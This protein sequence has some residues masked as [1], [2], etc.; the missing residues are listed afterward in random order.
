MKVLIIALISALFVSTASAAE[1]GYIQGTVVDAATGLPIPYAAVVVVGT[2]LVGQTL[3]DGT[4]SIYGVPAGPCKLKSVMIGYRTVEK[5]D[6]KVAA[7]M[8]TTVGFEMEEMVVGTTPEIVV[9]AEQVQLDIK[10][11]DIQPTVAKKDELHR[12]AA[13]E[14]FHR[15][16]TSLADSNGFQ[17]S[18]L[19]HQ[20]V[21][22][23]VAWGRIPEL[24]KVFSLEYPSLAR[25]AG[26]EGRLLLRITIGTNGQ[27][28]DAS[29]LQ[30]S[31]TPAMEKAAISA[32][33]KFEF[34]PAMQRDM[35][36]RSMMA[37]P[38][39]FRLR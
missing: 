28:E 11:S 17:I 3:A 5:N 21:V 16:K 23:F 34:T 1:V 39:W 7:S 18:P 30:S 38:V 2:K 19:P 9:E 25:D 12:L 36:V 8:G 20:E 13:G 33:M 32:V 6:V 29:V 35:P 10:T 14:E 27:V 37:V 31:V 26:I 15:T 22:E 4:Y 24:V